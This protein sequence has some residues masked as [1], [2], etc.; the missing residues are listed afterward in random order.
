MKIPRLSQFF[1]CL[2]FALIVCKYDFQHICT[3]FLGL[4]QKSR[5][6]KCNSNE[7]AGSR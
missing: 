3:Y 5:N 1:P 6:G 4:Q 7:H 2:P